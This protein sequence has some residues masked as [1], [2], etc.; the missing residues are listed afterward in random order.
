[1]Q[2]TLARCRLQDTP[3]LYYGSATPKRQTSAA[4]CAS[5]DVGAPAV[6]DAYSALRSVSYP[7]N[8]ITVS[9]A[10]LAAEKV[11][12]DKLR[13]GLKTVF[14]LQDEKWIFKSQSTETASAL[15]TSVD[16]AARYQTAYLTK[17]NI[18]QAVHFNLRI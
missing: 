15:K 4:A 10:A 8:T 12:T 18:D 9:T 11:K 1:M 7:G 14:V 17:K 3:R 6:N 13:N 5:T 16:A 2:S